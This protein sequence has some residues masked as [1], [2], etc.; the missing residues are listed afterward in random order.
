MRIP[1]AVESAEASGG[2]RFVDRGVRVN[3]WVPLRNLSGVGGELLGK[4]AVEKRRVNRSAAMV[5]ESGHRLYAEG[6]KLA[7]ALVGPSPVRT[8]RAERSNPFPKYRIAQPAD[9]QRGDA[10]EVAGPLG[11]PGPFQLIV[12]AIA[13][14]V[15]SA[16]DA[17]PQL[18]CRARSTLAT[19]LHH[20]PSSSRRG[21][22][23]TLE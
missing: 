3:P 8:Y 11:M 14:A 7:K 22:P 17:A 6:L 16:L 9:A 23:T 1:V 20:A 21:S 5:D 15:H 4:V 19:R 18:Q 13:D 12:I 10:A 2:E